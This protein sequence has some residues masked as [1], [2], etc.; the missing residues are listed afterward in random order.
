MNLF[1]WDDSHQYQGP[2][3]SETGLGGGRGGGA[4]TMCTVYQWAHHT[5]MEVKL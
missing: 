5:E 1:G 4:V 3:W 2:G